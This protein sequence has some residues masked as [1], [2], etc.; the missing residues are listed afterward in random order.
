MSLNLLTTIRQKPDPWTRRVFSLF[1]VLWLNMALQP[2]VMAF[3]DANDHGCPGCPLPSTE[4][5][6]SHS[7]NEA[8]DSDLN[9]S[10]CAVGTSECALVDDINYSGRAISVSAEDAPGDMPVG[11]ASS[12]DVNSPAEYSFARPGVGDT[13]FLPGASPPLHILYCVYLI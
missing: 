9:A 7:A 8:G 10:M 6:S 5:I 3:G 13:S 11:I 4:D 12:V 1:V 2:C